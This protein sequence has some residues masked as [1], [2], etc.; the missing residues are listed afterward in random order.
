MTIAEPNSLLLPAARSTLSQGFDTIYLVLYWM[1]V[2]LFFLIVG[3]AFYFAYRYKRQ[4]GDEEKLSSPPFHS[5]SLE[6]F[7]SVGPLLVCIGFFH[8]G[9]KEYMNSRVAPAGAYEIRVTGQKWSWNFEYPTGKQDRDLYVPAGRPVKLIMTSKDVLHS[10]FVPNYRIKYDVIPGRYS[11]VWFEAP[12]VGEDQI[13]CTEYCGRDHSMMLSKVFVRPPAEFDK[14]VNDFTPRCGTPPR[15]CVSPAEYGKE[16]YT[17]R[18][19]ISCHSIDGTRLVGPSFKGLYGKTEQFADG[20]SQVV[21]DNYI[22][23]SIL[24]PTAKIVQGYAPQMPTYQGQLKE[25]ELAGIIDFIKSLKLTTPPGRGGSRDRP[26][27]APRARPPTRRAR[28][29]QAGSSR[30]RRAHRWQRP[31]L[32]SPA[33]GSTTPAGGSTSFTPARG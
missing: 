5:T 1:S 13:Y 19:C 22:R 27:P 20:S 24:N 12:E 8:W 28:R 14:W 17:K 2:V 4:P 30:S 32:Q 7:W 16:L 23:E 10:F 26:P 25:P 31:T 15:D 33:P 6:L 29:E 21:D 18:A 11:M 3:A 9:V